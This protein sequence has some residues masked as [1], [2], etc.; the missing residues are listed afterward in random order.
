[1]KTKAEELQIIV[2]DK[3]SD[4]KLFEGFVKSIYGENIQD[5]TK[6][7]DIINQV[8]AYD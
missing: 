8:V 5:A 7:N 1:M 2:G 6:W 4:E 3:F